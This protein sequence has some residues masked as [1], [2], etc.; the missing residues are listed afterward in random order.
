[1]ID[2]SNLTD[3]SYVISDAGTYHFT[4]T[5]RGTP[6]AVIDSRG[7]KAVISVAANIT[8]DIIIILEGVN[9]SLTGEKQCPLSARNTT[10]T[11]TVQLKGD[12]TLSA[13]HG[14]PALWTPETTNGKLIIENH[15]DEKV[16]L[17]VQGARGYPG[18]G[19]IYANS[20]IQI[21]SGTIK[22]TGG[23]GASGIGSGNYGSA[24]TIT[25]G[26]VY[27]KGGNNGAG[28]GGNDAD[29]ISISGNNTI[30][31]AEGGFCGA[32]IGGGYARTG[33]IISISGGE[34]HASGG[35][36]QGYNS[37]AGI[38]GG[39][40]GAGGTISISGGKVYA[41]GA[42]GGAGI[43]GGY[44]GAAGTI[45]IS[46]GEVYA[47]GGDSY[48]TGI[49]GSIRSIEGT[50][51]ITG[52]EVTVT[53]GANATYDIGG[54]NAAVDLLIIG[55]DANVKKNESNE[56]VSYSNYSSGFVFSEGFATVKGDATLLA[57]MTIDA[58]ER[59]NIPLTTS[60]TINQGVTL[61]NEGTIQN[62]GTIQNNG[63]IQ[64]DGTIYNNVT[65]S[66][67]GTIEGNAPVSQ[68]APT[69]IVDF[70]VEGKTYN[71]T[72]ISVTAPEVKTTGESAE[73]VGN[74]TLTFY[75]EDTPLGDAPVNAG[76]YK[77]IAS[78][79]GDDNYK[80]ADDVIKTFTISK[81]TPRI[82][83]SL[84][85]A[86][87]GLVYDGSLKEATATVTGV[88]G[89][90]D[91]LTATL[92]YQKKTGED[93]WEALQEENKPTD[94]G[95]Y[96][97]N[98]SF[99]ETNNYISA[100]LTSNEFTIQKAIATIADFTVSDQRFNGNAI[101]IAAPTVTGVGLSEDVTATLTYKM[102]DTEDATYTETAPSNAGSYIVKASY[103]DDNHAAVDVTKEFNIT[104]ASNSWTTS[105]T[106]E[107]WTYNEDEKEP[108]AVAEQG[109]EVTYVYYAKATDADD[110]TELERKPTDA[111]TWY[112]QAKV[113]GLANYADLTSDY[114]AFTIAQAAVELAFAQL[115]LTITQGDAVPANALT[116]P[117]N[118]EV[119]YSSDNEAVATVDVATGVVTVVGVGT[120]TI[121]ATA[122]G[123]YTG[124]ASYT[125]TVNR[126]IPPYTPPTDPVYYTVTIPTEL[127]GAIIYGGGTHTVEEYTYCSFRIELDPNGNGEYP[128]VTK[129]YWWDTLTPDGQGNYSFMVTGDTEI[130]ISEVPT[131]SYSNYQLTF[132]T[133]SVAESDSTYWSGAYI[134][135][136]GA[137]QLRAEV[138]ESI[139]Y[140]APFG[141][142]VTLR[143]I[144]TERRKFLQWEDGSTKRERTLT[145]QADEEINALW[146][147]ISPVG[148]E[149]I[150]AN[151]VIRG[152]HGQLYIE[153]PNACEVVVYNYNGVPVRAA[154]LAAGVNRLMSLNAGL[155]I[156][157][158]G[159]AQAV[160]VRIR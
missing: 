47:T 152:E 52:G 42:Q 39:C 54:H 40:I 101:V 80:E 5:Y 65:I 8:E 73:V 141:K 111:G 81:A 114:V 85:T 104:K 110:Y 21:N 77:V 32:G 53:K 132:P 30:V 58:S 100:S 3:G 9:I 97:A 55:P 136:I 57:D 159:N 90:T 61:A 37:A 29:V 36:K 146:Q 142:T 60:L 149:T 17:T 41:I 44:I 48:G 1:M 102:K 113:T 7:C 13:I 11:V 66:G 69:E 74:A 130:S 27:A 127:K 49:G 43:G 93:S 82:S 84:P 125:L 98:A 18:I 155:Y 124:T 87:G 154:Q 143:P 151:S 135:V 38:G 72:P 78:Y 106:M 28:I 16:S 12:N 129:G 139:D 145:L 117:H 67:N 148:I 33:G 71:G 19:P 99:P 137:S 75:Q 109:E 24:I 83:I 103:T 22:A 147:H 79:S 112:V 116:N 95:T 94:A 150:V 15:S 59:L 96:R 121:T 68:K 25:G 118:C 134:E 56:A 126:Y 89:E 10:S 157:Q 108:S 62:D 14:C 88:E 34:V 76:S 31:H 91:A 138:A 105:L 35:A 6:S 144:E 63:T 2:L 46:G 115:T 156:V 50:I 153:V 123:N 107:G 122:G 131:S 86:D 26:E 92:S 120:A 70:T 45:S 140:E 160:P 119:T 20:Q 4:G 64:N 51:T 128:T 158:L 23:S 133:D